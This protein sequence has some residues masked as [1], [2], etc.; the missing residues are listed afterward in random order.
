MTI[1]HFHPQHHHLSNLNNP[2]ENR[3]RPTNPSPL[4]ALAL[5]RRLSGRAQKE[6]KADLQH[7]LNSLPPPDREVSPCL[8]HGG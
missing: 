2:D 6:L 1:N 3:R 7:N 4:L 8:Q 5:S